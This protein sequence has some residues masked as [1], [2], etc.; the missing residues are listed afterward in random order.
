MTSGRHRTAMAAAHS[1]CEAAA[2]DGDSELY[3]A[4]NRNFHEAIYRASRNEFL[5][6]QAL[7]LHKRLS[8]YR[9]VQLRARNRL[10][11]SL[12]EHAEILQAI[13]ADDEQL[14]AHRLVGHVL[15][16][17]EKSSDLMLGLAANERATASGRIS[18]VKILAS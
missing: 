18:R 12:E 13:R 1:V 7:S 8:A 10:L 3:Y 5:A 2:Q 6:E 17:G 4:V 15:I 16:Q 11:Q 9:R 14:A